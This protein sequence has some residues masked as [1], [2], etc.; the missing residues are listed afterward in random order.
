MLSAE[1]G[2]RCDF[3]PLNLS[4]LQILLNE[5]FYIGDC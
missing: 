3:Y 4:R 5:S 2:S 1:G